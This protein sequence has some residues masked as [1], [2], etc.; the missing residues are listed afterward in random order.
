MSRRVGLTATVCKFGA[1]TGETTG[2]VIDSD[3]QIRARYRSRLDS[4]DVELAGFCKQ[5]LCNLQCERGDSGAVVLN[6]KNEVVGLH[7]ADL[8]GNRS[9]VSPIGP[10]LDY[11]NVEIVTRL[12]IPTPASAVDVRDVEPLLSLT[13]QPRTVARAKQTIRPLLSVLGQA[14]RFGIG[15]QWR[16]TSEGMEVDGRISGSPGKMVTIPLIW[17]QFASSMRKWSYELSVPIELIMATIATESRGRPDAQR[18]EDNFV[19]DERTPTAVSAGLM[20][21]LISTATAMVPGEPVTRTWLKIADNSVRAG[22]AY[23]AYQRAM[24]VFDPPLVASAYN[25]GRLPDEPLT[26]NRWGTI[27]TAGHVDRFVGFFND[28]FR[29]FRS[30]ST[31]P[32]MSF[33]KQLHT[34]A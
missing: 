25:A 2:F 34:T 33:F 32:A 10:I 1:Q 16:L 6:R 4:D 21:T 24:T 3:F 30:D 14:R 29:L 13:E 27:H 8:G 31:A 12:R 15:V 26:S 9:I 5:I 23:I 19:S 28:S 17:E 7:F 20:Q 22:T 18:E 11:F